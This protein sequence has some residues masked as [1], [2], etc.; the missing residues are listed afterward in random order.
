M[1]EVKLQAVYH[2]ASNVFEIM[3]N[4]SNWWPGFCDEEYQKYWQKTFGLSEQDKVFFEGY[5]KIREKHYADPD[6]AEKDP[7]KNR[8]GL[9]ATLGSVTADPIAEA[10]YS[11]D[12]LEAAYER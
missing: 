2:E 3:D 12:S 1:A 5:R 11:S 10:F 9:C 4:V 8:N 6:Q 7:L